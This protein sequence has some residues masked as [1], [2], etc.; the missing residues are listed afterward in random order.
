MSYLL[1]RNQTSY[2]PK[3]VRAKDNKVYD[4]HGKEYLDASSNVINVNLGYSQSEIVQAMTLQAMRIPYSHNSKFKSELQENLAERLIH[5]LDNS[6]FKCYFCS[7]GSETIESAL[8][9]SQLYNEKATQHAAF[10]GSYHG[11]SLGA[12]SISGADIQK[13]FS[14]ILIPSIFFDWPVCSKCNHAMGGC[15]FECMKEIE[16]EFGKKQ[17]LHSQLIPWDRMRWGQI[18]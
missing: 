15:Q 18:Y 16:R 9:I 13:Q 4:S 6:S 10:K 8:R 11:S 3:V 5:F 17:L 14:G 2:H 7:S 12:L 1:H